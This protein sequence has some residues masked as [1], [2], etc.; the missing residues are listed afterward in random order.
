MLAE[1]YF[2]NDPNTCLL[3]LRQL[4]E[5]LA[6]M[7]AAQ[8]GHYSSLEEKQY[9]LV[10]RLQDSGVLPRKVFQLFDEIRRAGNAANHALSGDHRSAVST[11]K[12]TWQLGL[13]FHRSFKDPNY[14]SGPFLPPQAP[15]AESAE[16]RAELDRLHQAVTDF[17]SAHQEVAQK[18]EAAQSK[19]RE[20]NDERSFWEQLAAEAEQAKVS[21]EQRLVEQQTI[22]A[23]QP[24]STV[25][26]FITAANKAAKAVQLAEADTRKIIDQQLR[27]AGWE[28]DSETLKFNK[29]SRPEK[30]RHRAIAE[31]PT[32]SG[33]A[34]LN[35]MPYR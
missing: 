30:N 2:A 7:H 4:A 12:L 5:L 14:K 8:T 23:A 1:K 26:Q 27:Q 35:L 17:R 33:P 11:L 18:L 13:W 34:D 25:V 15:T 10:R 20:A 6:Q 21:L 24:K 3:K 19:L 31:W 22:A 9:D 29:G 28:V 16:L 32:E